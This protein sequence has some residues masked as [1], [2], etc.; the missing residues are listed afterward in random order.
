MKGNWGKI[1]VHT[2]AVTRANGKD[3]IVMVFGM[4]C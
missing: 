4:L 3:V 1:A 2:K